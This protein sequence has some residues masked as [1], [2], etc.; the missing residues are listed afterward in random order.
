MPQPQITIETTQLLT[1]SAFERHLLQKCLKKQPTALLVFFI[2]LCQR[3]IQLVVLRT[4]YTVCSMQNE[5]LYKIYTNLYSTGVRPL[6]V[7]NKYTTQSLTAVQSS[8]K[9]ACTYVMTV[10]TR[11]RM[12]IIVWRMWG[13]FPKYYADQTRVTTGLSELAEMVA[14]VNSLKE[15]ADSD[16]VVW[17]Q[18]RA[19]TGAA[20][21]NTFVL[22]QLAWKET[23]TSTDLLLNAINEISNSICLNT[24][25]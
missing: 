2:L 12:K 4:V 3:I 18:N 17:S 20:T 6:V 14:R 22:L 5:T 8:V 10:S 9:C 23:T 21:L 15:Y 19:A 1:F 13:E 7:W 16:T 11:T 25:C 24:K